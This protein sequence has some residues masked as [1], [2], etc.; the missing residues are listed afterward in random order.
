MGTLIGTVLSVLVNPLQASSA[1]AAAAAI[2]SLVPNFDL[3]K[4]A[5][6]ADEKGTQHARQYTSLQYLAQA[7]FMRPLYETLRLHYVKLSTLLTDTKV[8]K[9]FLLA[10]SF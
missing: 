7:L 8:C 2:T 6:I 4:S 3:K 1:A 9:V 10:F 5:A